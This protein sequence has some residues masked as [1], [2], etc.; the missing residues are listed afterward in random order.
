MRLPASTLNRYG[1][2]DVVLMDERSD[3]ILLRTAGLKQ[4]KLSWEDTAN[5]MAASLENWGDWDTT[6]ADGLNAIPWE[7][8]KTRLVA[9]RKASYTL[10]TSAG[11]KK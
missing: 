4:E 2:G 10:K 8:G 1:I 5:E 3:G 6:L 9:E 7:S 11:K